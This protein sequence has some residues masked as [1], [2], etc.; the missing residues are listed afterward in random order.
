MNLFLTFSVLKLKF[1]WFYGIFLIRFIFGTVVV[2]RFGVATDIFF[3]FFLKK[4][5]T[6]QK[7][8]IFASN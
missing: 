2:N 6:N 1:Y 7:N 5:V 8:Y 4:K 3:R